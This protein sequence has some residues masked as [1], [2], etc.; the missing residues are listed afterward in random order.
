MPWSGTG[1]LRDGMPSG[2][3]TTLVVSGDEIEVVGIGVDPQL[4]IAPTRR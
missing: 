4:W 2:H 3:L 1:F